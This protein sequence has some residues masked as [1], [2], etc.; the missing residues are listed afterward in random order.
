[1]IAFIKNNKIPLNIFS[2]ILVIIGTIF[3]IDEIQSDF[4]TYK[5][6]FEIIK[7]KINVFNKKKGFQI[8]ELDFLS[9]KLKILGGYFTYGK[10]ILLITLLLKLIIYIWLFFT[11]SNDKQKNLLKLI[12]KI[13]TLIGSIILH[14]EIIDNY[15]ALIDIFTKIQQNINRIIEQSNSITVKDLL[16]LPI[17]NNLNDYFLIG[18][19]LLIAGIICKIIYYLYLYKDPDDKLYTRLLKKILKKLNGINYLLTF[20][21]SV[22]LF[23]FIRTE[24]QNSSSSLEKIKDKINLINP[25]LIKNSE[26]I[27]IEKSN[28]NR[29]FGGNFTIGKLIIL[30]GVIFKMIITAIPYISK[31]IG[32][33]K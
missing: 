12:N 27:T 13:F 3:T 6:N 19:I 18:N 5:K 21:G 32:N 33:S 17:F 28:K 7:N 16:D 8:L 25:I 4:S 9:K 15:N 30:I 1:M 31:K 22:F 24:R 2:I 26:S 14:F 10:I 11:N 23:I 29:I 20:I